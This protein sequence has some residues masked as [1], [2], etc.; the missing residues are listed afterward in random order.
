MQIKN[1]SLYKP[2]LNQN[3][4]LVNFFLKCVHGIF[5]GWQEER[6][7]KVVSSEICWYWWCQLLGGRWGDT[8][9]PHPT[10]S[11]FKYSLEMIH[12]KN[13]FF[14]QYLYSH[15]FTFSV[16][17]KFQETKMN[18]WSWG[19][20]S[21]SLC[22]RYD[23]ISFRGWLFFQCE[24]ARILRFTVSRMKAT[25]SSKSF[26]SSVRSGLILTLRLQ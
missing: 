26:I 7:K 24:E 21:C 10:L 20:I 22:V 14:A 12:A 1:C 9:P 17:L 3:V 19:E 18:A 4:L 25:T 15:L 11:H 23:S 13:F 6:K 2:R 8:P 16:F 5:K